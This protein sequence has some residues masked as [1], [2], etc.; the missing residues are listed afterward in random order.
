MTKAIAETLKV[1]QDHVVLRLGRT[2]GS[3]IKE[4]F[5]KAT[6]ELPNG[7]SKDQATSLATDIGNTAS[8]ITDL[9]EEIDNNNRLDDVHATSIEDIVI[10]EEPT[11]RYIVIRS[12]T[13]MNCYFDL[14]IF[15]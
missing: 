11:G 5:L 4:Y 15:T 12:S 10:I 2:D 8:F 6:I 13:H 7:A 1:E 14:L 3:S 9:N